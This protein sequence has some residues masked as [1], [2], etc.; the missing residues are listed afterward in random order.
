VI[1][2]T[3]W[4]Y[5]ALKVDNI[6]LDPRNPRLP[7]EMLG[8][9]QTQIRHYLVNHFEV[10]KVARNIARFGFFPTEQML[11]VKEKGRHYVLEGN[12]RVAALQLLRNPDLAPPR[13]VK[14]YA[15]LAEDID[16][17]IWEKMKFHA[18]PTRDDAAPILIARH[19]SKM[20]YSWKRLMKHRYLADAVLRGTS[21]EQVAEKY[22]VS[23]GEVRTAALEI[24]LREMVTESDISPE[25]REDILK[26]TF[27]LSTVTRIVRSEPFLDAT[28][29]TL[30]GVDVVTT[31]VSEEGFLGALTK[32]FEDLTKEDYDSRYF[33]KKDGNIGTYVEELSGQFFKKEK[34]ESRYKPKPPKEKE[35][36]KERKPK[37]RN[38]PEML[39]PSTDSF[40]T[41]LSKLDDLIKIGQSMR[42][43]YLTIAGAFIL[44][45]IF[46]LA[47]VRIFDQ[48]DA[49]DEVEK[50]D[51]S[52]KPSSVLARKM[53]NHKDWF[54][55]EK[56]R[57]K[58]L[59]FADKDN[60][61]YLHI[62]TLHDY[63]HGDFEIP[64]KKDL[65]Q[66]WKQIEP[67]VEM[68]LEEE[69]D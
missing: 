23:K 9:N 58:L 68:A 27:P 46:E 2:F 50:K 32:L 44:R 51:G 17:A 22:G 30:D 37:R 69:P 10:L 14:S 24:I 29:M 4:D 67:I 41:G 43:G 12:R 59:S 7:E 57:R 5:I 62:T 35:Q 34:G 64:D 6:R 53:A 3:N 56:I 33:D 31:K 1:D 21:Y 48:H 38:K 8:A 19:A 26:D 25:L 47:L 39:I 20:N 36:E 40:Y 54:P 45:T 15:Q 18:A 61:R 65:E 66:F 42:R 16:V 49:Y 11:V 13:K 63:V 52:T 60:P 28:G 55:N